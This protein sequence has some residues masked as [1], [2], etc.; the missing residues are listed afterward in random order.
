MSDV[1][2]NLDRSFAQ[3]EGEG[4][5]FD[6]GKPR[7]EL[8]PG[9][10]L[11]EVSKVLAF[12]ARKYGDRNWEQ[13]MSWGRVVGAL[14]RHLFAWFGGEDKDPETGLNHTAHVACNALFLLAYVLRNTGTDDRSRP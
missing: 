9:D 5:K 12:G 13:G 14:L 3:P 1:M 11:L 6:G 2:H 8:L 10:A 4:R 7:L